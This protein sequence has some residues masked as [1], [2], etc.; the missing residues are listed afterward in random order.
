M[1]YQRILSGVLAFVIFV[2]LG[3]SITQG[4]GDI[5][6]NIILGLGVVLGVIYTIYGRIPHWMIVISNGSLV[7]D[8]ALG[9]IS[10]RI[11]LPILGGILFVAA[12]VI[13][14]FAPEV[15]FV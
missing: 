12:I 9:N 5:L 10:P 13:F 11:Y 2:L 7:A 1:S 8:D 4:I 3:W 6:G 15:F 14:I